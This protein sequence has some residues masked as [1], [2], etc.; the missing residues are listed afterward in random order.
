MMGGSRLQRWPEPSCSVFQPLRN[1]YH[2]CC[3]QPYI[4]AV[5]LLLCDGTGI[6]ASL[7][8]KRA[9]CREPSVLVLLASHVGRRSVGLSVEIYEVARRSIELCPGESSGSWT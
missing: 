3:L 6:L 7:V 9:N 8:C 1:A 2:A 5:R 4:T